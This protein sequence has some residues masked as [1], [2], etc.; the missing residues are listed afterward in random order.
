MLA[1]RPMELEVEQKECT[2]MSLLDGGM[3]KRHKSW[4]KVMYI[5]V[6]IFQVSWL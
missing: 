5:L 4:L 2:V 1:G 6:I 3:L